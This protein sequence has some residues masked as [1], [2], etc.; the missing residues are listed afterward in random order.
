MCLFLVQMLDNPTALQ[1][2]LWHRTCVSLQYRTYHRTKGTSQICTNHP[3]NGPSPISN[4]IPP[5]V[6]VRACVRAC[7]CVNSVAHMRF[8]RTMY[9]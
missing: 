9:V 1:S 7:V 2:R 3:K 5:P 8:V 4:R 6:R